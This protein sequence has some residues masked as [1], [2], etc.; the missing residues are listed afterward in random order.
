MAILTQ[1]VWDSDAGADPATMTITE[2]TEGNLLIAVVTERSGGSASNHAITGITGWTHTIS[3]TTEQANSSYR[4]SFSV[5]WKVA[6]ASEGTTITADDGTSNDKYLSFLEYEHEAGE[7]QWVL[8][9][10]ATNDNGATTGDTTLATGT[11]ASVSGTKFLEIGVSC[12]RRSGTE[13]D[14]SHSWDAGLGVD[15]NNGDTFNKMM[16][17]IGSDGDDTTAET[18]TSTVTWSGDQ[19]TNNTGINAGILVFSLIA[20]VGGGAVLPR[21]PLKPFMANLRR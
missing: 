6:G 3:E 1:A 7:D 20:A 15:A 4:R 16:Q 8:A 9:G 5:F 18:K 17:G 21:H 14:W 11:T 10:S 12:V 19:I 2:P 13:A